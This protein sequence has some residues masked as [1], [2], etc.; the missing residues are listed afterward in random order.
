MVAWHTM[1]L[2]VASPITSSCSSSIIFLMRSR[3]VIYEGIILATGQSGCCWCWLADSC[4]LTFW[5]CWMTVAAVKRYPIFIE[6]K[7]CLSFCGVHAETVTRNSVLYCHNLSVSPAFTVQLSMPVVQHRQTDL[8]L[9]YCPASHCIYCSWPAFVYV[10]YLSL[11]GPTVTTFIMEGHQP[12][13][14]AIGQVHPSRAQ[15][16]RKQWAQFHLRISGTKHHRKN[17]CQ[18]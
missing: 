17:S 6:T 16:G 12:F 3:T 2:S 14:C 10:C 7:T 13:Q 11:P 9:H 4:T 5:M 15:S 1:H 18:T 8:W